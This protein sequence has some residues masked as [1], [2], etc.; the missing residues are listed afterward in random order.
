MLSNFKRTFWRPPRAHGETIGDR[1]VGF[2]E[3]FYDLVYV[4]VIARA[5]HHPP[6]T[7]P[8]TACSS[9]LSFSG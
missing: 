3:L 4:V 6:P 1:S 8:A 5:T 7:S 2:I 9:S